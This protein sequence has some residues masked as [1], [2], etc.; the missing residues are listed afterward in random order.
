MGS[1]F[2]GGTTTSNTSSQPWAAQQPYELAGL[3]NAQ[4]TYNNNIAT[5]PYSGEYVA[6]P[7][8]YDTNAETAAGSYANG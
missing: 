7:N 5:G 2:G 1:L 8:G 6:G 3:G 4:T